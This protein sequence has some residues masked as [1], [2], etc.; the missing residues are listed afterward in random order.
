MST[1]G[2]RTVTLYT[3]AGCGLCVQAHSILRELAGRLGF[4]IELVDI[5]SDDDL[6]RR[7][8]HSS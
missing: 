6:L 3:R 5:E 1:A 7:D 8:V 2:T 4:A